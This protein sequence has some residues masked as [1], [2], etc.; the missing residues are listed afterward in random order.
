[1]I[2]S[3]CFALCLACLTW[4]TIQAEPPAQRRPLSE[5]LAP[6][7]TTLPA[8]Q[9]NAAPLPWTPAMVRQVAEVL[10]VTQRAEQVLRGW[11]DGASL[12]WTA[13][14][15]P[16]CQ[17]SAAGMR[18]TTPAGARAYAG[19][20]LDLQRKQDEWLVKSSSGLSQVLESRV[21]TITV[22][23]AEEA[24]R[25]DKRIRLAPDMPPVSV[26]IVWLR[27]GDL[28]VECSWRDVPADTAWAEK[29][30]AALRGAN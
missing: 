23:G 30:F 13:K 21:Q 5:A 4:S 17:V 3:S 18:F 24:T 1:V 27:A 10:G 25:C 14:R 11:A 7:G 22:K 15:N 20:A 28:I 16:T 19:L 6:V 8:D 26:M 29:V 2:R 12:I 9:W